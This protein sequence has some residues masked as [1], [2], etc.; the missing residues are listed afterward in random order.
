MPIDWVVT[1][2]KKLYE[3]G[4]QNLVY[5]AAKEMGVRWFEEMH[6]RVRLSTEDILPWGVNILAIGGWGESTIEQVN[7]KEKF[8]TSYAE[9]SPEAKA[10][11]NVGFPVCHFLRGCGAGGADIIF[12]EDCH[13]IETHCMAEGY[14]RCEFLVQ[15]ARKFN[16][17]NKRV[18]NSLR[19][20][21]HLNYNN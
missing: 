4:A 17:R 15:S 12:G 18:K 1:L 6:K 5:Y 20:Q 16:K 19:C 10:F 2:E 7:T 21:N 8:Y 11:G 3:I 9:K 14:P 13:S